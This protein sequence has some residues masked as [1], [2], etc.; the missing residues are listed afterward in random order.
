MKKYDLFER[1]GLTAEEL[2]ELYR[3]ITGL[4]NDNEFTDEGI[5]E[6]LLETLEEDEEEE[7]E[8]WW[9]K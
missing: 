8:Q 7:E 6:Y 5:Y 2:R 1:K 9:Q 4:D 3:E